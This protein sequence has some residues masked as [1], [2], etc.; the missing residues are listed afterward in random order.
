MVTIQDNPAVALAQW[1]DLA[2]EL[3]RWGEQGRIATLWWRDDDAVAPS[4]RLDDLLATAG[5]VPVALAVIPALADPA[6]AARLGRS[7]GSRV[8][9]L[10][11]GWRHVDH[12]SGGKKSEFPPSRSRAQMAA[13]LAEG[14]TRLIALFGARALAVLAP[15]WNR[16][17]D[18]SLSLLAANGIGAISRSQGAPGGVA[19]AGCI[20]RQCPR[21][22]GRLA[23]RSGVCRRRGGARRGRRAFAG[24]PLRRG[25]SRRAYR[26]PDPP[27]RPGR[28]DG[29]FS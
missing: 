24:A 7:A 29:R 8:C 11:H 9:V 13:D 28:G 18:N 22:S 19:G 17:D 2:D 21:R 4:P 5:E 27:S 12:A 3:D 20:C 10:Q 16:F 26:D 14:R 25:R 23:R 15:P 6:L 1:T